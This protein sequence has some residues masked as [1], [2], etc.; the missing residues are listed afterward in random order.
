MITRRRLLIALPAALCAPA[1]AAAYLLPTPHVLR[2]ATARLAASRGLTVTLAGEARLDGGREVEVVEQWSFGPKL[3]VTVTA[4]ETPPTPPPGAP[5][6][7]PPAAPPAS[8][9]RII[10]A[11]I[12]GDPALL[13][14]APVRQLLDLLF[15]QADPS[16]V[17]QAIG[18][19]R[20]A[21]SLALAGDRVVMVLG[22]PPGDRRA[23]AL[24]VD[25]DDD[26]IRRVRFATDIGDAELR[27]DEW[28]GPITR[29]R[30]PHRLTVTLAGRPVR[31][32]TARSM[33]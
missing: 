14:R 7:A 9:A 12:T 30:F 3:A 29:G 2:K 28:D 16:A 17:M 26:T 32:L 10:G 22:A 15:A 11:D 1:T 27:L 20:D 5:P 21:Q 31:R 13:P 19:R 6:L 24:W 33:P 8:H 25:N 23:P 4:T 18:A